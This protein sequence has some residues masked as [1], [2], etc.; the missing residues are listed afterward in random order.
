MST[1][2]LKS[3]V[4]AAEWVLSSEQMSCKNKATVRVCIVVAG[5]TF[6]LSQKSGFGNLTKLQKKSCFC[7][8]SKPT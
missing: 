8:L 4:G 7:L 5:K 3:G 1:A 6:H 2:L